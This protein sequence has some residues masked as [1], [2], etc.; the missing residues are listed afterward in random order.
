[1]AA[2]GVCV[3][4]FVCTAVTQH[5]TDAQQQRRSKYWG[6]KHFSVRTVTNRDGCTPSELDRQKGYLQCT[7]KK[8]L[9][10]S[11]AIHNS[12]EKNYRTRATDYYDTTTTGVLLIYSTN[13]FCAC[14]IY[15]V[16]EI[17]ALNIW[18]TRDL[19]R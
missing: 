9:P 16:E 7:G 10:R 19:C 5:T 3:S 8:K 6:E 2:G 15:K 4:V 18:Q 11:G 1:M 17:V 12:D 13:E 14:C